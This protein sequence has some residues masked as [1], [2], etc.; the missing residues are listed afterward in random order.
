MTSPASG[1]TYYAP[2]TVVV[3]ADA[4]DQ[5][6]S[7]QYVFFFRN[8]TTLG[9]NYAAPYIR[10]NTAVPVGEY[11]YGGM[12]MDNRGATATN[13]VFV[14]VLATPVETPP[15]VTLTAPTN[16]VTFSGPLDIPVAAT[17]IADG[18][19]TITGVQFYRGTTSLINDTVAPYSCTDLAVG[20]GTYMYSAVAT[21]SAAAKSTNQVSVTVVTVPP[22]NIPPTVYFTSP[23][24][25]MTFLL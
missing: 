24:N 22:V 12:A 6:G 8:A 20:A 21:D 10:T 1:A 16:G 4:T 25:G 15:T 2:A 5:D 9:T 17:A 3:S 14:R 18:V 23:T 7:V 13:M 11:W 19:K